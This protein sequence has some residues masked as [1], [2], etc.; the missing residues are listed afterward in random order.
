MLR[1]NV[2]KKVLRV[3]KMVPPG[4]GLSKKVIKIRND[5]VR[6][7]SKNNKKFFI[8]FCKGVIHKKKMLRKNVTKKVLR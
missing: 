8:I 1:K 7:L 5:I 3:T 6:L 2:T 4:K